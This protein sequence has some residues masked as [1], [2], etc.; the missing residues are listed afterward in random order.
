MNKKGSLTIEAAMI[1]PVFIILW[2]PFLYYMRYCLLY[3]TMQQVNHQ[4]AM[5]MSSAG[6]L[7]DRA[8][9]GEVQEEVSVDQ[10]LELNWNVSWDETAQMIQGGLNYCLQLLQREE[11]LETVVG[12]EIWKLAVNDVGDLAAV[13]IADSMGEKRWSILGASDNPRW[14]YSD[15][16]YKQDKLSDWIS[17]VMHVPVQWADPFDI[18]TDKVIAVSTQIRVFTGVLDEKSDGEWGE[19]QKEIYYRIGRGKKYHSLDC[20]LI[21]KDIQLV[22]LETCKAQG[23]E[24]CDHCETE[25]EMVW[26]TPGGECYHA[27]GCAH[28]FPN[29]I[30]LSEEEIIN[31]AYTPCALCQTEGGWFP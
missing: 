17:L 1:F 27:K 24:S 13:Q 26:V 14:D 10:G 4:T 29:V 18:F 11:E 12:Q 9:L 25:L 20:Y 6:Y 3:E 31:G 16:F 19:T 21:R 15:F 8:G 23:Y 22:D 2:V 30:A 28:L 7:F 5:I